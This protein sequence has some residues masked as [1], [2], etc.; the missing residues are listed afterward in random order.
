MTTVK[1]QCKYSVLLKTM[2]DN[3]CV[4]FL[5]LIFDVRTKSV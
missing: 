4:H 1:R 5:L 3:F 2:D